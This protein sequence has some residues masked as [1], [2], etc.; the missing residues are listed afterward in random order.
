VLKSSAKIRNLALL[1]M[2]YGV[3]HRWALRLAGVGASGALHSTWFDLGWMLR[4][5]CSAAPNEPASSALF[6]SSCPVPPSLAP[7]AD[8][9][10]SRRLFEFAWKGQLRVLHPTVQGYQSV[11][12]DV[13]TYTG[14]P[15]AAPR[16][17]RKA[18]PF[19]RKPC[20]LRLFASL[21]AARSQRVAPDAGGPCARPA[22]NP[23]PSPQN[24]STHDARPPHRHPHAG[25]DGS[26]PPRLPAPRLGRRRQRHAR[27]DGRG[28][29][30]LLRHDADG[31]GLPGGGAARADGRADGRHRV[32]RGHCHAGGRARA[33]RALSSSCP[34][35]L[36]ACASPG[37]LE[38]FER[39]RV[40]GEPPKRLRLPVSSPSFKPKP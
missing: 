10:N 35:G 31:R 25:V 37:V 18:S 39:A 3:A 1:V 33:P 15:G 4:A 8:P 6:A 12:A 38:R 9:P 40:F 17:R 21:A 29:R 30:G 36:C 22:A 14:A 2:G 19:S 28:R 13:S 11:L 34:F 7:P 5:R 24:P 16:A 26:I 23:A 20:G 27:G 32:G